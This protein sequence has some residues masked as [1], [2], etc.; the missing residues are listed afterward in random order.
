MDLSAVLEE[1]RALPDQ[2]AAWATSPAFYLQALLAVAAIVVAYLAKH[3]VVAL[4]AAATAQGESRSISIVRANAGHIAAFAWPLLSLIAL[5]IASD[6]GA[7]FAGTSWLILIVRGVVALWLLHLLISRMVRNRLLRML[8]RWTAIPI[9]ILYV[10][11]MLEPTVAYLESVSIS[12]GNINLSAYGLL[13]VLIFGSLLFW[14]GRVSS[15]A[16]P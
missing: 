1:L 11:G 14:L 2:L 5:G 6:I 12:A 13:R 9:A 10:F 8:V 7:S 4:T 3:L 16:G 15:D